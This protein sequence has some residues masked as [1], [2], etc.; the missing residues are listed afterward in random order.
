VRTLTSELFF[1]CLFSVAV[2]HRIYNKQ[3]YNYIVILR[4]ILYAQ[5]IH[6]LRNWA[7][8]DD[9]IFWCRNRL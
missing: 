7:N 3:R 5:C 2:C 4:E 1:V 6:E 9:I 8:W